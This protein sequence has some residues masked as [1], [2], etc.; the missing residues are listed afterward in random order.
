MSRHDQLL[1]LA[2][3][4][5][6]RGMRLFLRGGQLLQNG[7]DAFE[8]LYY[9][10]GMANGETWWCSVRIAHHESLTEAEHTLCDLKR[11][12]EDQLLDLLADEVEKG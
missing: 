12:W 4:H 9:R 3:V 10:R 5:Q 1:E 7:S 8:V 2:R 11:R 6:P